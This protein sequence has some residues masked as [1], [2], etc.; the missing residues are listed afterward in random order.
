MSEA[1]PTA[2]ALSAREP[3]TLTI[4]GATGDLTHR[5][6]LPGLCSLFCRNLLPEPL[7]IV[8][9]ARREYTD[10]SFRAWTAE[11]IRKFSP[12]PISDRERD[13][14]LAHLFYHRA[15]LESEPDAFR[16]YARR[17][18]DESRFP[19]NQLFYLSIKPDQFERVIVGLHDAGLTQPLAGGDWTRVVVEKPFGRDLAS[20][21]ALN[22]ICLQHLQEAQIYRIDHYLGKETVQNVMS[23]RF[24]N[25]IFEPLFNHR[26]VEHVQITAA[27]TM[28]MER[29]RG[30]FY[31]DAGA[32]RD[33]VQN[34][35]L[36]LLCLVAME[37]PSRMTADSIRNEKVKLLQSIE[38]VSHDGEG[39]GVVRAQYAAGTVDG[40]PVPAYVEEDRV[41]RDSRTETFVALRLNIRNWRWSGV[42]FYLRTGKRLARRMTE[43]M[44]QFRMPPL[45]LFQTVECEGDVCDLVRPRPN[46]LIF[47]IQPEEGIAL[48]FSAKRPSMKLNV[49]DV[50]MNFSYAAQWPAQLPEAYE[51]L[52]L[53]AARGDSTLFTRSDEVEAAWQVVAPIQQEWQRDLDTPIPEYPAGSWGPAAADALIRTRG[54]EWHNSVP[55]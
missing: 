26:Y 16:G 20:A 5:K 22:H 1:S 11:S 52:L 10:E 45:Q 18:A 25:T 55:R 42:P 17:L 34:H 28:G 36:Q 12:T 21:R 43:V 29:G 4:F 14:F 40:T 44:V 41:P 47:R 32:L 50:N 38:T 33:M 7:A 31:H 24:A 15:D 30:A 46:R 53:D 37:P 48:R 8:G 3:F 27:E 2:A 51:R 39:G 9:F 35:L 13:A 19:R 23:F 54:A 49:E 6:L